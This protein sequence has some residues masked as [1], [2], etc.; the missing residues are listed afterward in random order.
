MAFANFIARQ[1]ARPYGLFGRLIFGGLLNRANAPVN[2]LV[3][4][5]L[6]H[7]AKSQVTAFGEHLMFWERA[8]QFNRVL[9][10]FAQRCAQQQ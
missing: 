9:T 1:S 7:D 10:E 3:Y 8:D 2:R 4:H 5:S 6:R